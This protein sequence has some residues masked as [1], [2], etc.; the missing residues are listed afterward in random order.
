MATELSRDLPD[1]DYH[2]QQLVEDNERRSSAMEYLSCR[3][4][5]DTINSRTIQV[6]KSEQVSRRRGL[7]E[8]K[9][10]RGVSSCD[11]YISPNRQPRFLIQQPSSL[12]HKESY[13]YRINLGGRACE[14]RQLGDAPVYVSHRRRVRSCKD[15][16][17]GLVSVNA[18][19]CRRS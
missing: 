16:L 11:P 8:P 15:T 18:S 2:C 7:I 1:R 19:M 6:T 3:Y 4:L 9:K 5:F 10:Q 12:T 17:N 14:T 13:Y